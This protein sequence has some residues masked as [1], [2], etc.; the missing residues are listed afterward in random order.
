MFSHN[1]QYFASYGGNYQ[2]IQEK[3]LIRY[4]LDSHGN[5]MFPGKLAPLVAFGN[6]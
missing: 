3:V 5:H 1:S 6:P 2:V 4:Y